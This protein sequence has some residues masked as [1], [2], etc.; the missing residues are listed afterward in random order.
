MGFNNGKWTM[1]KGQWTMDN[2]QGTVDNVDSYQ[3]YYLSRDLL[4]YHKIHDYIH[5]GFT[6]LPP[7][8]YNIFAPL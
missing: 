1:D 2:G 4:P 3:T 8:L 7:L 5:C 6:P